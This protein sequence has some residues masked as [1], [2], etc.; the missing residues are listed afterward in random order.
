M[1]KQIKPTLANLKPV[2]VL[3]EDYNGRIVVEESYDTVEA[4]TKARSIGC[5]SMDEAEAYA[6]ARVTHKPVL[7]AGTVE[8]FRK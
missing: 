7:E 3:H 4:A 8:E 2:L 6:F 1:A 5:G